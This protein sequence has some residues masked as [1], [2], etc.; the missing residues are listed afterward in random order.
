MQLAESKEK[1][2]IHYGYEF[3]PDEI[4]SMKKNE[5]V[6]DELKNILK[7]SNMDEILNIVKENMSKV[8]NFKIKDEVNIYFLEI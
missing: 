1:S 7:T 8:K 6:M 5:F 2:P 3:N 4:E